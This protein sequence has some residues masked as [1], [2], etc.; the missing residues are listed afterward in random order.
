MEE[1]KTSSEWW[2]D[3]PMIKTMRINDPDGW[4][5]SNFHYS[6]Y[7]EPVTFA[8]FEKRLFISTM[9]PREKPMK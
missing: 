3:H 1:V 2:H 5:R 4:D 7:K 9:V 6:F 8:E